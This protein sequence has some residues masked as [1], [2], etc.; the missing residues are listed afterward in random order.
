M[1]DASVE[2]SCSFRQKLAKSEH[3]AFPGGPEMPLK[4]TS[5]L[6]MS[7]EQ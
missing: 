7:G 4:K 6:Q 1:G 3:L 2:S 5:Q